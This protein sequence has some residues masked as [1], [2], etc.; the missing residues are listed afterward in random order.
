M[1]HRITVAGGGAAA[2]CQVSYR[3]RFEGRDRE[4]SLTA[5]GDAREIAVGSQEEFIT[6]HYWGYTRR[7]AVEAPWSIRSSTR[8]GVRGRP[9][10][11]AWRATPHGSTESGSPT[12]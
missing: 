2:I 6:E 1:S 5:R 4:I 3:W 10:R 11:H 7:G 12:A 9:S 8:A